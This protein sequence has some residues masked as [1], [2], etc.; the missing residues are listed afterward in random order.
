MFYR[1][2]EERRKDR[3]VRIFGNVLREAKAR[4]HADGTALSV[5]HAR[6]VVDLVDELG[7]HREARRVQSLELCFDRLIA[8]SGSSSI[9]SFRQH[10]NVG[11]RRTLYK[12]RINR[13]LHRP[14]YSQLYL[15]GLLLWH[16]RC[17]PTVSGRRRLL[18]CLEAE[19]DHGGRE[20][21][22]A[23]L[24]AAGALELPGDVLFVGLDSLDLRD[25][26][27]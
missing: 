25:G 5:D 11:R 3:C 2:R 9:S 8:F 13:K 24:G 6:S 4:T 16:Q 18:R 27:T 17:R 23:D 14:F 19:A 20:G 1:G 7:E 10:R 15:R 21:L 22:A 12:C 26:V